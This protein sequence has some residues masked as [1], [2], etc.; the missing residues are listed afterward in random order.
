M[1][2]AIVGCGGVGG[3]FGGRLAQAG[4]SVVFVARGAALQ[5]LRR[6]GLHVESVAGDF[7]VA[8][9]EAAGD[10]ATVGTVDVVVLAVKAWQVADVAPTLGPMLGAESVVLPLENGV[11][12][13]P[14]LVEAL[15]SE[16]VLGGLCKIMSYVVAPGRIRHA[17]VAPR[18]ELGELD[19]RRSERVERLRAA[20]GSCVG[21]SVAVPEDI[22]VALWE[23]FLFIAPFSAVG[24]VTRMPAGAIRSSPET[25]RMLEDATREVF[26]LARARGVALRDD[27]VERTLGFVDA[28]PPD[29]TASMQRDILEGRASELESQ[30]GAVVRLAA[31]AGL[32]VPVNGFLYASLLPSE[33][34]ARAAP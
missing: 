4:E 12:A 5:A 27:A 8:P 16:K 34:R 32:P 6:D 22:Q 2:I 13:A 3:Y 26:E 17:G 31:Q 30:T 20:F 28:L 21:V 25:R 18:V 23:K 1:R 9:A 19:G 33:R 10:P 15:G 7:R 29:A 14:Q 24:A 11:E